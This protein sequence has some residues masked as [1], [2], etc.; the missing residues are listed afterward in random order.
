MKKR[1]V[2]FRTH[3]VWRIGVRFQS[4]RNGSEKTALEFPLLQGSQAGNIISEG[5]H[6]SPVTAYMDCVGTTCGC[7]VGK[8]DPRSQ[9][10]LKPLQP[11]NIAKATKVAEMKA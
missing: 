8:I 2:S 6:T 9:K 1:D 10:P 7:R 3:R 11:A 4:I 5:Q